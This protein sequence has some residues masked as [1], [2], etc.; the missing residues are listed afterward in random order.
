MTGPRDAAE[1]GSWR[2]LAGRLVVISGP[3]GVGK[4]L[5]SERLTAVTGA[6]RVVTATSRAPRSG[7]CDGVD[8]HFYDRERF[9]AEI[10]SGEF[11]EH[12]VV[13]DNLYGTPLASVRTLLEDGRTALLVIDVQGA[14]ALMEQ[15][16][17]ATYVFIEPPTMEELE[18]R[19]R[20]R[21][22]DDHEAIERRLENARGELAMRGR[23]DYRV[24]NDN[25]DDAVEEL[26]MLLG[27]EQT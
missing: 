14:A 17:P 6:A 22:S 7:E 5:I 12:A 1:P 2:R 24:V 3:S 20:S 4:T 21:G 26:M 27:L 15:E 10:D 9:R 18:R 13:H 23:Y 16:T 25:P 19:L 11:L 8:Y